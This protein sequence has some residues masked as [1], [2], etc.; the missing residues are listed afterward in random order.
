[1][2]YT[3]LHFTLKVWLTSACVAPLPF[4]VD[5]FR[6][7]KPGDFAFIESYPALVFMSL[8]FSVFTWLAFWGAMELIVRLFADWFLRKILASVTGMVLSLLTVYLFLKFWDLPVKSAT[9]LQVIIAG[10]SS[11]AFGSWYFKMP[12]A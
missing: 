11:V 3:S 2:R 6:T 8:A 1:M 9:S 12:L 5:L 4:L 10:T 7:A